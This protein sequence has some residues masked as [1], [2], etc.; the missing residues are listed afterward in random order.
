MTHDELVEKA[1]FIFAA[2]KERDDLLC[3]PKGGELTENEEADLQ[4]HFKDVQRVLGIEAK[5]IGSPGSAD[6][7]AIA[8]VLL[9][10]I[11]RQWEQTT[12]EKA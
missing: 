4:D 7:F 8:N 6:C 11:N 10:A 5:G 1:K 2:I 12:N 3:R 9:R